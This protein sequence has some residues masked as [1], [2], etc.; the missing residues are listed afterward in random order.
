VG[1]QRAQRKAGDRSG[2][3]HACLTNCFTRSVLAFNTARYAKGSCRPRHETV[4]KTKTT[5]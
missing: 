5:P 3:P 1:K 4:H 2:A